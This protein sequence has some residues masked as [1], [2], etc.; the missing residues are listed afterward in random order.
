M[1]LNTGIST[2]WRLCRLSIRSRDS[3]VSTLRNRAILGLVPGTGK[4]LLQIFQHALEHTP[5]S[6]S[7]G[8]GA[9]SLV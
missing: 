2:V 1:P 7:V 9:L 4:R 3:V 6:Y 5:A 8:N